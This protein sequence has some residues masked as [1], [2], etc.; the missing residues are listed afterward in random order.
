VR[1]GSNEELLA[2]VDKHADRTVHR[3]HYLL[4]GIK[5]PAIP[6]RQLRPVGWLHI[7]PNIRKKNPLKKKFKDQIGKVVVRDHPPFPLPIAEH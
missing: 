7:R 2:L 3:N 4:L 6:S 1:E 5:E